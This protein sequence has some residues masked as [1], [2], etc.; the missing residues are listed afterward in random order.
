MNLAETL[1]N[2]AQ[3]QLAGFTAVLGTHLLCYGARSLL[4]RI[5]ELSFAKLE[6]EMFLDTHP[7]NAEAL[8]YLNGLR[9]ELAE[10]MGDYAAR[11]FALTAD[12]VRGDSWNWVETPFPWQY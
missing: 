11:G 1:L 5:Q 6:A 9:G 10:A 7:T 2:A 12:D 8:A 3:D 4:R